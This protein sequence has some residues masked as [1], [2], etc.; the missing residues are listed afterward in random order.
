KLV[1]MTI[2]LTL[3]A[4]AWEG[5]DPFESFGTAASVIKRHPAQFLTTYTITGIIGAIMALPLVPLAFLPDEVD[6]PSVFWLAVIIYEGIIWTFGI[7][8][9]QMS[10]GLLYL[11]HLKWVKAK[12]A[13]ET[14]GDD[15]SFVAQPQL[16]DEVHE[17][18]DNTNQ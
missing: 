17:L 2:F 7:Y 12:M 8:M 10:V 3:P 14:L 13:D 1:R 16:L 9:E 15:L 5:K 11:W 18:G 6:L 4:I